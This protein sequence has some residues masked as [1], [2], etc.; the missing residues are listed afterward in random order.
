MSTCLNTRCLLY[1]WAGS[2]TLARIGTYDGSG[3]AQ[4][5][6][7]HGGNRFRMLFDALATDYDGTVARDGKV[8]RRT[9][10]GLQRAKDAGL[11]LLLVTGRELTDLSQ[12]FPHLTVFDRIVAENGAVLFDPS[13]KDVRLLASP[14]PP[15]LVSWLT[16]R[17]VP[18]SVGHSVVAS[19]TPYEPVVREAIRA[20][21]LDWQIAFNK[22]SIMVLPAAVTKATGLRPAL[23]ELGVSAT[24]TVAVGDAENDEVFLSACGLSVAVANALPSL[25]EQADLVM[26]Q[27]EG[28]GVVELIDRLL[29]GTVG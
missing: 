4:K 9:L 10:A 20:L 29:A 19:T 18:M 6:Q 28:E 12:T 7:T 14:P 11:K 5:S 24:R 8:D 27:A 3:R 22:E 21:D 26:S 15:A 13:T 1:R 25:K 2:A 16:D 23:E 17:L